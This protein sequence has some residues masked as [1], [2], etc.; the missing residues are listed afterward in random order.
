ML[1]PVNSGINLTGQKKH[2]LGKDEG[3]IDLD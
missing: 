3:Q 1:F 2:V